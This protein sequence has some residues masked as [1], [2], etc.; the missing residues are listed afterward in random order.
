MP[1]GTATIDLRLSRGRHSRPRGW[2]WPWPRKE[3][4]SDH[5]SSLHA[6]PSCLA[7]CSGTSAGS[8]VERE[9]CLDRSTISSCGGQP[10]PRARHGRARPSHQPS[11]TSARAERST[12]RPAAGL[13]LAEAGRWRQ[14]AV[15]ARE[16]VAADL[17][18]WHKARAAQPWSGDVPSAAAAFEQP[19]TCTGVR[20]APWATLTARQAVTGMPSARC[21][22]QREV[23]AGRE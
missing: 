1:R 12:I 15:H 16:F 19:K 2:L 13:V 8:A 4:R 23:S 3:T 11:E 21:C 9:H 22:L 5:T 10:P 18:S 14:A 17:F 20:Q 7:A 6:W